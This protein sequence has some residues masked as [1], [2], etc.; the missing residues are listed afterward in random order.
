ML[1]VQSN[2]VA[3]NISSFKDQLLSKASVVEVAK[4]LRA[5]STAVNQSNNFAVALRLA[6]QVVWAVAFK[7]RIYFNLQTCSA[8]ARQPKFH[9]AAAGG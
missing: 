4:M 1:I 3:R 7:G 9:W 5:L 2:L 6:Q 8:V